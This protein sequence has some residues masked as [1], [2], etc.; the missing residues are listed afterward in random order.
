MPKSLKFSKVRCSNWK[1]LLDVYRDKC[2]KKN[3]WV[4]RGLTDSRWKLES[5]LE[6]AALDRLNVHPSKLNHVER[7]LVRDFQRKAHHY[8]P[9]HELPGEDDYLGW[10]ALMRHHTAPSRLMDWTYSFWVAVHFAILDSSP[11]KEV[12]RKGK[13]KKDAVWPVVWALDICNLKDEVERNVPEIKKLRRKNKKA[14]KRNDHDFDAFKD[15][16]L[17]KRII[18]PGEASKSIDAVYPLNPYRLNARLYHQNGLFLVPCNVR[19]TFQ[20]NLCAI[21][22][23]EKCFTKVVIEPRRKLI[24]EV[25]DHLRRMNISEATLFPGLDGFARSQRNYLHKPWLMNPRG[26]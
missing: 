5:T 2:K 21:P 16:D 15:F 24:L 7:G 23:V 3:D 17:V 22:R 10:L 11:V 14:K 9:S 25:V 8:A 19:R 6:R 18:M 4:F 20:E 1:D 26:W 13:G 12:P